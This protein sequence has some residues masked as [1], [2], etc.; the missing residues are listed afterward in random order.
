MGEDP[1]KM[2]Q[3]IRKSERKNTKQQTPIKRKIPPKKIKQVAKFPISK[4]KHA[5]MKN[6]LSKK[7]G[8]RTH[9]KRYRKEKVP[10][11]QRKT[12]ATKSIDDANQGRKMNNKTMKGERKHTPNEKRNKKTRKKDQRSKKKH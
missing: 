10:I 5:P 12:H 8:E 3:E 1:G 9:Q 6:Q 7:P 11:K 2:N 4:D